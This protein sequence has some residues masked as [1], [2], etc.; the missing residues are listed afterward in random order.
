MDRTVIR[1]GIR[2]ACSPE[3]KFDARSSLVGH[4]VWQA[5]AD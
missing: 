4:F 1:A 2:I 3:R 5:Y